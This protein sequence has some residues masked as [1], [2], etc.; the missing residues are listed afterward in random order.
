MK[1]DWKDAPEWA[2]WL[3]QDDDDKWYWYAKKPGLD[4]LHWQVTA[5]SYAPST[6]YAGGAPNW[7]NSLEQRPTEVELEYVDPYDQKLEPGEDGPTVADCAA[8]FQ[9]FPEI[10]EIDVSLYEVQEGAVMNTP[11]YEELAG[12]LVRA[13]DQAA[14]GK[15]KE[16]H[17]NDAAFVNQPM[18][19]IS[20]L[21][22]SDAGMA[23]QAIKKIQE[24]RRLPTREAQV[25]ELLGAINYVAGMVLWLESQPPDVQQYCEVFLESCDETFGGKPL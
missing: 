13:Y 9:P 25:R 11:G 20:D 14:I 2:N 7:K 8:K 12:V 10:G 21:L 22:D 6:E 3:A 15:G 24:A 16:R 4:G 18:Q 5:G 23:F 1:P 17:A 19:T